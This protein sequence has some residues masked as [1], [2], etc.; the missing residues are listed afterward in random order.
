MY[1]VRGL[2]EGRA[3]EGSTVWFGNDFGGA[4]KFRLDQ[5]LEPDEHSC[6]IL[7]RGRHCFSHSL[8][9]RVT[10][11]PD[12]HMTVESAAR[13]GFDGAV[14]GGTLAKKAPVRLSIAEDDGDEAGDD[15]MEELGGRRRVSRD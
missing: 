14:V 10:F 9:R 13:L 7:L 12:K 2:A 3:R 8:G 4:K 5:T 11:E 1:V 6:R 15:G